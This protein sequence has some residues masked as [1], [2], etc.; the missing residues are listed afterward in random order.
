M[1]KAGV[2]YSDVSKHCNARFTLM[3]YP[4]KLEGKQY[5]GMIHGLGHGVGLEIHEEPRVSMFSKD[6]CQVG[7]V[8]TIEPG[9]YYPHIGGCRIEDSVYIDSDGKVVKFQDGNPGASYVI[10]VE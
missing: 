1:L 8:V 9:L 7:D 3:G 10:E 2:K 6:T 5:V 4:V